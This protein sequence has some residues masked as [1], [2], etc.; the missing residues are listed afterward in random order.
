[1]NAND[2]SFRITRA[3]PEDVDDLHALIRA[4]ADYE[5]LGDICTS[6]PRDL[7]DAL[8]GPHP[9]AEALISRLDGKSHV[10]IGFALFFHTY[11][12]FNGRRSLWL[13]DLFV[14][15][16]HRGAGVGRA[17]LAALAAV[18]RER[19]CG[20]FEWA[21]LDWNAP[22][23]RFYESLGARVLPDWRIARVTGE[24]LA[25]LADGVSA[26]RRGAP[27]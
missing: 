6:T 18:A 11:S 21:V 27:A 8:F 16:E 24:A 20:R 17:L 22:A 15:P 26:G 19:D 3:R 13:E 12:T 2:R 4:L 23:I 9:V 7:A 10:C 25:A 14:R 1:M 5:R